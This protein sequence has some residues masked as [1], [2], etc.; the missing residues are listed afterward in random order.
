MRECRARIEKKEQ[1]EKIEWYSRVKKVY[2]PGSACFVPDA[3]STV[4][5]SDVAW[6]GRV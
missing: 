1:K 2:N 3:G 6:T 5:T 4:Q